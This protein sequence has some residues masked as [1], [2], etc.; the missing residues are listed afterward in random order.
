MEKPLWVKGFWG[1]L[2]F[3][4][5]SLLVLHSAFAPYGWRV[6]RVRPWGLHLVLTLPYGWHLSANPPGNVTPQYVR[7]MTYAWGYISRGKKAWEKGNYDQ[8]TKYFQAEL[9]GPNYSSKNAPDAVARSYL[10][11]IAALKVEKVKAKSAL[12]N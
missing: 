4:L 5:I 12:N 8:A 3:T 1:F 2:V 9:D 7:N 10:A 11:R 6:Q